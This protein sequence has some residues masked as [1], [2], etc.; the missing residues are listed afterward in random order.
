M[1]EMIYSKEVLCAIQKNKPIVA[2]ESTI[3]SHGLPFPENYDTAVALETEIREQGAI[4][5]TIAIINGQIKVGLEKEDLK[6]CQIQ[7]QK[8]KKLVDE[9]YHQFYKKKGTELQLLLQQ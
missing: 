7:H 2:L 6:F 3:I 5:A 1:T 4:P 9:I 8:L